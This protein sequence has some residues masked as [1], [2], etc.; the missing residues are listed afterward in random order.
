MMA[1]F[2]PSLLS[3]VFVLISTLITVE[4]G[5][6]DISARSKCSSTDADKSTFPSTAKLSALR[7]LM[8]AEGLTAYVIPSVDQHGSE[9]IGP[10]DK[11]RQWLSSFSGS[12]GEVII[13]A[14]QAVLWTDGRY[15]LQA[16]TELDCNWA[17]L[18]MSPDVFQWAAK[19]LQGGKK[20]KIG[21]DPRLFPESRWK[22]AEMALSAA[23]EGDMTL[24]PT[25]S[26]IDRLWKAPERPAIPADA[27]I[28]VQAI[29]YAGV[30]W[31]EKV[32]HLRRMM[33][34]VKANYL[35]VSDLM[36]IAWL[37]NLRGKADIP[38]NPVFFSFAIVPRDK[39][40]R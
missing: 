23:V 16:E 21:A 38:Y 6:K 36:E 1:P 33:Q 25:P 15:L 30:S 19:N 9:Y 5:F 2:H 39:G 8:T 7:S 22:L 13:T 28:S 4:A 32:T 37:F 3:L 17:I 14:D 29:K 11:R 40:E 20:H 34:L 26:L 10:V 31:E 27:D 18:E 12:A 24:M 35:V